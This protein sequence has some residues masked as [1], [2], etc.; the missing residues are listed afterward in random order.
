MVE[1]T[2]AVICRNGHVLSVK[3]G[4]EKPRR[5]KWEFPGGKVHAGE[6]EADSLRREIMEELG[7]EIVIGERLIPVEHRY[8]DIQ[9]RLIP[10]MVEI[11]RGDIRL[12]DHIAMAWLPLDK[13][14]ELDWSEADLEV[15]SQL[16]KGKVCGG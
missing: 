14:H 12:V 4:M 5:G 9:I 10:F 11:E 7:V 6:E 2:C 1:V 15:L 16:T 13:L 8:P 3:R